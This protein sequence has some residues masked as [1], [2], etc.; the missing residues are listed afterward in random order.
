M[1]GVQR[2]SFHGIVLPSADS[3]Y[4]LVCQLFHFK[5]MY[6]TSSIYGTC[7]KCFNIKN[8]STII[9]WFLTLKDYI[10]T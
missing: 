10:F 2:E 5:I 1:G 9:L 3:T 6:A 4:S 7:S 8:A